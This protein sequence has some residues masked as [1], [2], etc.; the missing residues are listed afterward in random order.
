MVRRTCRATALSRLALLR[1]S[2]GMS[3]DVLRPM[4]WH[5]GPALHLHFRATVDCVPMSRHRLV[6]WLGAMNIDRN[7]IGELAL[8]VT[9][10]VTNAVEASPSAAAEVSLRA[11]IHNRDVVLEVTDQ[12][13]GFNLDHDAAPRPEQIRGRGLPIVQAS[14]D[15]VE[16]ERFDGQTRVLATRRLAPARL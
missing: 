6:G 5:S 4:T 3:V 13:G 16:V 11:R 10:L 1:A 2:A 9:E 8:V 15:L 14:V 12:G 7:I